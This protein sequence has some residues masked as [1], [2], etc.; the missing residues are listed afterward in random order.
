MKRL[1]IGVDPGNDSAGVP[2]WLDG[3]CLSSATVHPWTEN[4]PDLLEWPEGVDEADVYVEVPQHGGHQSR[5]GVHW[6]AGMLVAQLCAQ[7]RIRRGR[8]KKVRPDDW[9]M[10]A[11]GT[12][13]VTKKDAERAAKCYRKPINSHDEAEAVLIGMYGEIQKGNEIR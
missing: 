8:V 3:R 12:K 4:A 1:T 11:L 7:I 13:D 6:A 10:G 2:L 9:R 5:G